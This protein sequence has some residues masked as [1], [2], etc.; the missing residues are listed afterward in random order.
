MMDVFI[1]VAVS[2]N[3]AIGK[4]GEIPWKIKEDMK[5]FK[6]LTMGYPCIMG[7]RTYDSIPSRFRPLPGRENIVLTRRGDYRPQG[8]KIMHSFDDA[9]SYCREKGYSKAA[10]IGGA[11]VY[12]EG[13]QYADIV[14]LTRVHKEFEGD[15][16][17]PELDE[18]IWELVSEE[19]HLDAEI[20]YSFLTYRRK[21]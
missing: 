4:D 2:E 14:E 11:K 20:P 15:A 17:F 8:A 19:K 13:L 10:I 21:K 12:E 16:F 1:V 5:R 6:D 18:E 9:L 3:N 7:S